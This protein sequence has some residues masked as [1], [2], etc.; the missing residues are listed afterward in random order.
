MS[1]IFCS[2]LKLRDYFSLNS[3]FKLQGHIETIFDCKF[4]PDD[5]YM[6]ATSSFDGT[7]KVWNIETL[8]AVS[9]FFFALL[10]FILIF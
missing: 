4:K 6:L 7:I 5:P 1:K 10:R 3:N 9:M 8:T 2:Y